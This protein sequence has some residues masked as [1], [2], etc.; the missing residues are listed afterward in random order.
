M[1]ATEAAKKTVGFK[2]NKREDW[3]DSNDVEIQDLLNR[4]HAAHAKL[5]Q[6]PWSPN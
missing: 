3:F 4:K 1:A 6:C 5:Q 2:K